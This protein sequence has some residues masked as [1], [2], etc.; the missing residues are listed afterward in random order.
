MLAICHGEVRDP[1]TQNHLR[2]YF[3]R[4][5]ANFSFYKNRRFDPR[6]AGIAIFIPIIITRILEN[7][8]ERILNTIKRT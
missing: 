1:D 8:S 2:V 7:L 4:Q 5:W 6:D 3:K